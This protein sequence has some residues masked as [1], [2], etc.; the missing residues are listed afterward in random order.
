VGDGTTCQCHLAQDKRQR[1]EDRSQEA[2]KSLATE[3]MEEK[4]KIKNQRAK[5]QIKIQNV[6]R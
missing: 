4:S 1:T 6:G 3:D 5:L 2:E